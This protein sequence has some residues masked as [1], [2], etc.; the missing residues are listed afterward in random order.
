M[1]IEEFWR[2]LERS[3]RETTDRDQRTRW[4]EYRLSRIPRTHIVDFQIQLDTAR[5]PLDT[6]A[7]WGAAHQ[8]MDGLC[9]GD[10]FWYF[11][12]WLIGQGRQSWQHAAEDPDNL[13]DIPAVRTLAGRSPGEWAGAEWPQWEELAYVAGRAYDRISG[14]EDSVDEALAARG[15]HRP[16]GPHPLDPRWDPD[17]LA[18]I[19]QRLPRLTSLFPRRQRL[20]A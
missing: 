4:L 13:V 19:Q 3:G 1:D 15:H 12:P 16:S 11:Q 8:I 14:R 18:E 10:G 9:S 7:M 17:S 20:K 6:H 2:F 5:R